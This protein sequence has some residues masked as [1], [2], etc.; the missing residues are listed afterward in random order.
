[1]N[2]LNDITFYI[3]NLDSRKDRWREIVEELKKQDIT[4]YKRF[5]AI[6]P[7]IPQ[8][9]QVPFID[10]RQFWRFR[11]LR[12]EN[13]A[14]YC[15]GASGCKLSHYYLLKNILHIANDE[16]YFIILE[17]DCVLREKFWENLTQTL[18]YIEENNIDFNILY[19]V[20]NLHNAD[21]FNVVDKNLLKCN[22]DHGH[23]THSLL[24]K[25]E[26]IP[27]VLQHIENSKA[28]IDKV[29]TQLENRYIVYPMITYQRE[30][31]SNICSY[32]EFGKGGLL[33]NKPENT[34]IFYGYLDE[35]EFIKNKVQRWLKN[36]PT[37]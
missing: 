3:I 2:N 11:S 27:I 20:C 23:T 4:S 26:N 30:T 25:K 31:I 32:R 24:F 16:K 6:R 33:E 18:N 1:M 12:N 34:P 10:L 14:K 28:E 13:D 22:L 19:L 37:I 21:A 36:N 8:I 9:L 29:Y 7:T 17:D 5:S 15:I 35:K